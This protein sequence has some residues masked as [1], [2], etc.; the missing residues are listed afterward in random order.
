MFNYVSPSVKR[1]LSYDEK[2]IIGKSAFVFVHPDDMKKA[3]DALKKVVDFENK[4]IATEFRFRHRSGNWVNL[5]A[6]G[7]N[8]LAN[9]SINGIIVNCRDVTDRKRIEAQLFNSQKMEAIGTLAGG[10]AHDF[11]NILMGIQGYISLMLLNIETIHPEFEKLINIQALVQS[12]ADLTGKLLGFARGGQYEVKPTDLNELISKTVNLFGRTKK[13]ISFHQK[14]EKNPW[15]AEVDRIQI[16][17]VLLNLFVNAWQ[18]MP[19]GGDIYIETKNVTNHKIVATT[20][21]AAG[22]YINITITD[23]GVGMDEETCQRIFEPFFT[24]KEKGRGVGLGLASAY[25]IIKEH[26]GIIEVTSELG[27]GTT[28]NIFLPA[29]IK[30]VPKETFAAKTI[31]K[32]TETILL[33]DDEDSIL[34]VCREILIALGYNIFI[35][36]NGKEALNIYANEQRQD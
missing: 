32:G 35:A 3:I 23:T 22:D 2:D 10:I 12:G 27:E 4:G 24:T 5:E 29:S 26:G 34:D 36:H 13:D 25:G 33:V 8:C 6:L 28:F 18:A 7:N 17:Q 15:T 31:F 9:P 19:E 21:I 14:Y 1:I 20:N 11:N 16:E 30:E